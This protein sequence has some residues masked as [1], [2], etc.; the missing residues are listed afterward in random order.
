MKPYQT[1]LTSLKTELNSLWYYL[2]SELGF[3][4]LIFSWWWYHEMNHTRKSSNDSSLHFQKKSSNLSEISPITIFNS[5]NQMLCFLEFISQVTE[6]LNFS[7]FGHKL[8]WYIDQ[9]FQWKSWKCICTLFLKRE[10]NTRFFIP[11]KYLSIMKSMISARHIQFF[12]DLLNWESQKHQ[13]WPSWEQ[14]IILFC[15]AYF[16]SS[17]AL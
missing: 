2:Q 11:C 16:D 12:S 10:I 14:Y 6:K 5:V 3:D 4:Q 7:Y 8:E 17:S 1:S 13:I 15:R 9:C